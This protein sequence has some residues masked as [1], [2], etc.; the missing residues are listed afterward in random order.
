MTTFLAIVGAFL[1][2][3]VGLFLSVAYAFYKWGENQPK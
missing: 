1:A 3:W 2:L